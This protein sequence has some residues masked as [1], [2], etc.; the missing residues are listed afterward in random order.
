MYRG[1]AAQLSKRFASALDEIT[2]THGFEYGAEFEVAICKVLRL[3]LPEK[4][5]VCRG[6]ATSP[7]GETAGD[8]IIIFAQD[9]FPTLRTLEGDSFARKEYVPIEA[10]YAYIECKH[11][12][13]LGARADEP[14]SLLRASQQV[15]EVKSLIATRDRVPF[16]QFDSYVTWRGPPGRRVDIP[17]WLPKYRNPPFG[18]V[19][20]RR[21]ADRTAQRPLTD[22]EQIH[23]A[24]LGGSDVQKS[25]SAVDVVVCGESNGLAP[26]FRGENS[27]MQN[28]LFALPDHPGHMLG[29]FQTPEIA[30]GVG[31]VHLMGALDWIRLG[32]MPWAKILNATRQPS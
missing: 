26:G 25:P 2:A 18:M 13:V 21:V 23:E 22:P 31:I 6:Y 15:Q 12:L 5:G 4:Y 11:T 24:L 10:I 30:F 29:C 1:Y 9:A 14:A 3:I 27:E 8:D 32:P 17:E 20:S 28:L 16:A 19:F 7:Q